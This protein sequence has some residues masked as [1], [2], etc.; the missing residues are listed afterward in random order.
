LIGRRSAA[1]ARA[2]G[3]RI[4]IALLSA[5]TASALDSMPGL[6]LFFSSVFVGKSA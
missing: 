5:A 6:F 1:S 2:R 3:P 4:G